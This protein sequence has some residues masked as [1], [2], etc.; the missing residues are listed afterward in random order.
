MS[1]SE[2]ELYRFVKEIKC[3]VARKVPRHFFQVFEGR[4]TPIGSMLFLYA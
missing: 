3:L 4:T 1:S 2:T